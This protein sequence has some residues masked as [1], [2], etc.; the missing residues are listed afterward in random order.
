[1]Q[2]DHEREQT[3][4]NEG[5][6]AQPEEKNSAQKGGVGIKFCAQGDKKFKERPVVKQNKENGNLRTRLLPDNPATC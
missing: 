2:F 6:N 1:M 4:K 5:Q 3:G